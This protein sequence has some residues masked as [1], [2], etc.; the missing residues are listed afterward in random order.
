M[1]SVRQVV[2]TIMLKRAGDLRRRLRN[3]ATTFNTGEIGYRLG[4]DTFGKYTV[5]YRSQTADIDVLE[6]SFVHD[7]MFSMIPEFAPQADDTIIDVGSHIGT[8][9]LLA[10]SKVPQGRVF[11]IEACQET[12]NYLRVNV[13]LNRA[14]NITPVHLA[15]ADGPGMVT[16]HY[17]EGNWGHSI[18]KELSA[19]SEQVPKD[20]LANLCARHGVTDIALIKFNCEGAEFPI[21]LN[22]P[23]ELLQ[24]VRLM[25]VLYHLDLVQGYTRDVL[26]NRLHAAGFA[27]DVR[28]EGSLRG[29]I[30]AR[31]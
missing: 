26:L 29:C 8:F 18:M 11:A 24:K 23:I 16:L 2:P 10:A 1:M 6:D 31:H 30:V 21:L 25:L 27:T 22:A 14:D 7:N 4:I 17:D 20:S 9:A 3:A 12:F 19:K 5:A 15:L 13:A 28:P